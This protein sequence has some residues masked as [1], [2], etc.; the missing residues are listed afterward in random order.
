M[1]NTLRCGMIV[2][3][4]ALAGHHAQ[5]T[6]QATALCLLTQAIHD[7]AGDGLQNVIV[8]VVWDCRVV[9]DC[10]TSVLLH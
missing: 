6:T 5:Q 4:P 2:Y 8:L 10:L 1:L 9:N 3:A 7:A